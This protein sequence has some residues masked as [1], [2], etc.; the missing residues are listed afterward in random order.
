MDEREWAF[1]V[2]SM[3]SVVDPVD[4]IIGGLGIVGEVKLVW[5]KG[6][7]IAVLLFAGAVSREAASRSRSMFTSELLGDCWVPDPLSIGGGV[8]I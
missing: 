4:G 2:G 8:C 3:A 1:S 7:G 5:F 6:C